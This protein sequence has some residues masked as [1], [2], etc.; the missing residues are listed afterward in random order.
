MWHYEGI[1]AEVKVLSSLD[2]C[3]YIPFML[4][5][6]MNQFREWCLVMERFD[7][8]TLQY[9]IINKSNILPE[10]KQTIVYQLAIALD[11]LHDSFLTHG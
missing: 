8:G 1:I 11:Y 10:G 3:K 5:C 6:G 4:Y 7:G 2:G 9:H